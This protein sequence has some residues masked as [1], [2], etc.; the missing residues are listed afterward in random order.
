MTLTSLPDDVVI[1]GISGKFPESENMQ[2][3]ADNLFNG[4]DMVTDDGRRF[5]PGQTPLRSDRGQTEV[6]RVSD[7]DQTVVIQGNTVR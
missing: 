4:V 3:F 1:S 7:N 5:T 6:R 2:E